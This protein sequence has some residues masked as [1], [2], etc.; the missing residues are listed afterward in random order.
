MP[1]ESHQTFKKN[2]WWGR[3]WV[4]AALA[5]VFPRRC[6]GCDRVLGAGS[7]GEA[8]ICAGCAVVVPWVMG[9]V[10]TAW[11][12]NLRWERLTAV[13]RFEGPLVAA[14]HGL[15]YER[16]TDRARALSALLWQSVAARCPYDVV[17]AVPL[18]ADRLRERGYNQS[19]L[20]AKGVARRFG[21]RAPVDWVR[22]VRATRPQVGLEAG[23]RLDNVRGAFA[24]TPRGAAGT[25]DRRVLLIDDVLTTGATLHECARVLHRAGAVRL[26]VAVIAVA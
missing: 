10:G 26:D 1:T 7:D 21:V 25:R 6:V 8:G 22:R 3:A 14:I 20:L 15:K 24:M 16:R 17:L 5:A 13:C 19:Q 23:A 11:V 18:A 12:P 4:G 2:E 9:P